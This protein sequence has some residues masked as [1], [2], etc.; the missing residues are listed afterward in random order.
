MVSLRLRSSAVGSGTT[1]SISGISGLSVPSMGSLKRSE[2][3]CLVT[4]ADTPTAHPTRDVQRSAD[5]W[6]AVSRNFAA[7]EKPG[8]SGTHSDADRSMPTVASFWRANAG[9][10][11]VL[12]AYFD[13]PPQDWLDFSAAQKE[14]GRNK[15][16][17]K[18]QR[19][20]AIIMLACSSLV[21]GHITDMVMPSTVRMKPVMPKASAKPSAL[22]FSP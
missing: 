9:E 5:T 6:Q 3:W 12:H 4:K 21:Y 1:A 7:S 2:L 8:S 13:S 20:L 10:A 19:G 17:S 14:P 11:R 18:G 15:Q 22:S 16:Y